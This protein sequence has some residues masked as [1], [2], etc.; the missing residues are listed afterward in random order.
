MDSDNDPGT[1]TICTLDPC[2]TWLIKLWKD[3]INKLIEYFIKAT[4]SGHLS[5]ATQ[6]GGC[7]FTTLKNILVE[8]DVA[9]YHLV[10][11]CAILGL[12]VINM[13]KIPSSLYHPNMLVLQ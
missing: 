7:L 2:P 5:L 4:K 10:R 3:H 12:A 9:N 6:R 11:S 1:D 8:N 13:L